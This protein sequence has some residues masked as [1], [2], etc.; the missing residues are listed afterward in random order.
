MKIL[1]KSRPSLLY[2]R[3]ASEIICRDTLR[4]GEVIHH[5]K[6][7]MNASNTFLKKNI[8]SLLVFGVLEF[9]KGKKTF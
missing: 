9:A 1:I 3:R 2:F 7:R 8:I 6:P 5:G 4:A